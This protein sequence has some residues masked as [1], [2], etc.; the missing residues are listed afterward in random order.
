MDALLG[1]FARRINSD[2]DRMFTPDRL[3]TVLTL[4]ARLTYDTAGADNAAFESW[5]ANKSGTWHTREAREKAIREAREFAD[6]VWNE[7]TDDAGA[8]H[9]LL[10]RGGEETVTAAELVDRIT[11]MTAAGLAISA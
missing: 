3:L 11:V 5:Y 7:A 8:A 10:L 1:D 4:S 2:P 9:L 6:Y